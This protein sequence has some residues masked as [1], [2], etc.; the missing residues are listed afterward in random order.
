MSLTDFQ[1][2]LTDMTLDVRLARRVKLE[3]ARALGRYSLRDREAARL[4]RVAQQPG[5]ALNCTLARA[6]RFTSICDAYPM[7]CVVLEPW[8]R[9]LLDDLWSADSPA[10]YQLRGEIDAFARCVEEHWLRRP[11]TEYLQ[12]VFAYEQACHALLSASRAGPLAA[13]AGKIRKVFFRHDPAQVLPPLRKSI[14]PPPGLPLAP[15]W[16]EVEIVDE[17]LETRWFPAAGG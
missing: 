13:M 7:S 16:V 14:A 12:E 1:R 9:T 4:L 15:H 11:D 3:G 17:A 10:D 8:L 6:N 5:M 2:A